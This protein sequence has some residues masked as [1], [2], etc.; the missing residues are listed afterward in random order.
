MMGMSQQGSSHA[1]VTARAHRNGH[2][3]SRALSQVALTGQTVAHFSITPHHH[4]LPS[5]SCRPLK[6]E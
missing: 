2:V 3:S 1:L 5:S 4:C 6:I